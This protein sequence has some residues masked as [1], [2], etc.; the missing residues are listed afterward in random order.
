MD[1]VQSQRRRYKLI[2]AWQDYLKDI[3]VYVG[4]ADTGAHAQTGHP[5]AVVQ[6]GFGVRPAGF[7]GR[8]GGAG[9]GGRGDSTAAAVPAPPPPPQNP[10][11]LC[12]QIAGNLYNDDLVLAVAH[13][14]QSNTTWH[15][16]RPKIA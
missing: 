9:R 11:P 10:Q 6:M 5:V 7:G 3:D 12:T 2:V 1:F 15:D 16:E 8:G 14:Y 13:K 4:A